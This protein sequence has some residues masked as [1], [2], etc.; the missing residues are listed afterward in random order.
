MLEDA[1]VLD[2]GGE[3]GVA[4]IG[5]IITDKEPHTCCQVSHVYNDAEKDSQP[6]ISRTQFKPLMKLLLQMLLTLHQLNHFYHT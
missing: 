6:L 4:L 5:L 1:V 3:P 2:G